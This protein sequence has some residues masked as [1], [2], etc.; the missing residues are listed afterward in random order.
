MPYLVSA[1]KEPSVYARYCYFVVGKPSFPHLEVICLKLHFLVCLLSFHHYVGGCA[2][3]PR[4]MTEVSQWLLP[5]T[6][7]AT[8]FLRRHSPCW[9]SQISTLSG[10]S[11]GPLC[12]ILRANVLFFHG[13]LFQAI[14]SPYSYRVDNCLQT[15]EQNICTWN[16]L[17]DLPAV[18]VGGDGRNKVKGF[19]AWAM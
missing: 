9:L 3:P 14:L 5:G 11:A 12:W 8:P 4:Q 19:L 16:Y 15:D 7:W 10:M 18:A 1:E 13:R 6:C 2:F 17:S